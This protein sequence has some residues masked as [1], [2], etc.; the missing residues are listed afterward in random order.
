[1]SF[2]YIDPGSGSLMVQIIIAFFAGAV[3]FLST[4][5]HRIYSLFIR[6]KAF[7]KRS[8]EDDR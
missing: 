8:S 7:F 3:V 6:I 1:M 4:I 2:L 5:R